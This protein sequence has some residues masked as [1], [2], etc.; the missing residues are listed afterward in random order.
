MTIQD[1]KVGDELEILFHGK[2]G[3]IVT[4]T[5]IMPDIQDAL[6][7]N[8]T[9]ESFSGGGFRARNPGS[10]SYYVIDRDFRICTPVN[11]IPN[12]KFL[13]DF[14]TKLEIV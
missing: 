5:D 8:H 2:F 3:D 9:P 14:L 13:G 4:I 11:T 1:L 7:I 10:E 12:L 6:W